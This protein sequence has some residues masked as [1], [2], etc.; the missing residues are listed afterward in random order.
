MSSD[1]KIHTLLAGVFSRAICDMHKKRLS[2][3]VTDKPELN[4]RFEEKKKIS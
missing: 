2:V 4:T 3:F 1:W